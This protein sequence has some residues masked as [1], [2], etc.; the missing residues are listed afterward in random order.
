[1]LCMN[2]AKSFSII[3]MSKY[4]GEKS[5]SWKWRNNFLI[6]SSPP[7][8][9]NTCRAP[10]MGFCWRTLCNTEPPTSTCGWRNYVM[11][12]TSSEL[13]V[14][15]LALLLRKLTGLAVIYPAAN[16]LCQ[17]CE[18]CREYI[19]QLDGLPLPRIVLDR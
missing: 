7:T 19:T 11:N 6:S 13:N 2:S 17:K 3:D 16:V 8:L 9:Y 1:M 12:S 14:N 18:S 15:I 4:R 10:G 5:C